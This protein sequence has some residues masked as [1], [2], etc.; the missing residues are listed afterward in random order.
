MSRMSDKGKKERSHPFASHVVIIMTMGGI[1]AS[2]ILISSSLALAGRQ[3]LDSSISTP[4]KTIATNGSDQWDDDE[5]ITTP[6]STFS[7]A[8]IR[9][10]GVSPLFKQY[11]QS[12]S[13][14]QS[15]GKPI[16]VAFPTNLGWMQFFEAG[17]LLLPTTQQTHIRNNNDTLTELSNNSIID[18]TTGIARLPLLQALLTNGS[19]VPIGGAASSM[20]YVI[21]RQATSPE[22]MQPAPAPIMKHT[23][24]SFPIPQLSIFI[25]GGTRA[26]KDVGHF[27]PQSFWS[28]INLPAVSPD[29]WE[30][31]FGSPLT[32]TLPFT[33]EIHG[34][35]HHMLIQAFS[36]DALI[37]D[38]DSLNASGQPII[39]RLTTGIDYLHTFG[40][41]TVATH[42]R[43]TVWSQGETAL[44]QTPTSK[45]ALAHL[46]QNFPL[47]LLGD[48]DW[49]QGMLWY[50]VQW[51]TPKSSRSGWVSAA[52]IT[53]TSPGK[54][55]G[56]AS[57]DALSPQLSSY[58]TT[59]GPNVG[60]ALYDVTRQR[61]YTYNSTTQFLVAS[62]IKVPIMAAFFDMIEQQGREPNDGEM[63][64]LITMI[65]NS[66][67]DSASALYNEIGNSAGITAYF[68]KIG[69][70]GLSPEDG[71]WGYSVITPQAMVDLLA[72]LQK[73][74]ILTAK[75][76]ATALNLMENIE[77][78][79]KAGVGDT[80]P[81]G[82][83][84]AM[85]DGWVP[86]PD[87]LWAMNTS[88]IVTSGKE[89]YIISVYT[90]EQQSLNDGQ[91]IVR[92]VCSTAA[93]LLA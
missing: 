19:Q 76:R 46:G 32:E 75:D 92:Q 30:K 77:S 47:S 8:A 41:P 63:D 70:T 69:V 38:Q 64:L 10:G 79:Q 61:Y 68:Q 80:A 2:A 45:H 52:D 71:S 74:K 88:G 5:I 39:Q 51:S 31:D 11:Y 73:G 54:V 9:K 22:L 20:T 36:H 56:R 7:L 53:F 17:A 66:N 82:F 37:L 81:A 89:T 40:L 50:H 49:I 90:Q 4:V 57:L 44:R 93:S 35:I 33:T 83:T 6:V 25:K 55:A 26:G 59:I 23:A 84:I 58:L 24:I 21:L 34:K 65:E 13:T 15:L 87:G 27:I 48:T 43:Q 42:G 62:S 18:P 67:N 28:Y 29:G 14:T 1:I 16:T 86:G 91:V 3:Y 12:H 60:V 72:L 85:K 78:D